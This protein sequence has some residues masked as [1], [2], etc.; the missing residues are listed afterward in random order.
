[1]TS[2]R[3]SGGTGLGL[4]ISRNIVV[5]L[6]GGTL[7]CTSVPEQGATFVIEVPD[8]ANPDQ[9]GYFGGLKGK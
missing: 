9:G 5:N 2:S 4:A 1:M 3:G 8:V 7:T 6:L